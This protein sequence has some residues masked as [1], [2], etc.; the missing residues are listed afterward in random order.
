MLLSV[1]PNDNQN[2]FGY[3][4]KLVWQNLRLLW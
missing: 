3:L 4:L 2:L 1:K